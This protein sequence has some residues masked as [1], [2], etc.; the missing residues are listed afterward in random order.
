MQSRF[1]I[2][3]RCQID[4]LSSKGENF[5]R[6]NSSTCS[7]WTM[8]LGIAIKSM[9]FKVDCLNHE[10]LFARLDHI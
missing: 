3:L 10:L 7:I 5:G 4:D 8:D 1:F 6:W 2:L 9:V